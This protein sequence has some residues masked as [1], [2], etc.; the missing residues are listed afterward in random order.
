MLRKIS[1]RLS[2]Q[3]ESIAQKTEN[4]KKILKWRGSQGSE[5]HIAFKLVNLFEQLWL[6]KHCYGE[7][8]ATYSITIFFRGTWDH[9][10]NNAATFSRSSLLGFW[11]C[12]RFLPR[13]RRG[14]PSVEIKIS[15]TNLF[16]YAFRSDIRKISIYS[17][18]SVQYRKIRVS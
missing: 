3:S 9:K 10:N 11:L 7:Y 12:I 15:N 8:C 17:L 13:T 16:T 6:S 5:I 18:N 2:I 4:M 14:P 1:G